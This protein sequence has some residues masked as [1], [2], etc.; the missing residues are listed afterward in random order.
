MT[1][2]RSPIRLKIPAITLALGLFLLYGL[3]K[4][5]GR[6]AVESEAAI[7]GARQS[8]ANGKAFRAHLI[9][10]Q[11]IAQQHAD[12]ARQWQRVASIRGKLI[13]QLDT[14][15]D[16]S[17]TQRESLTVLVQTR[18]TLRAQVTTCCSLARQ[19]ELAFRADSNRAD[20]AERRNGELE[21]HLADVLKV[22]ECHMLGARWLP[23]CP[24]RTASFLLGAGTAG[25]LALLLR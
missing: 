22:A 7:V 3:G 11:Q 13:T 15:L 14:A 23:R 6:G 5:V 9:K 25:S 20:L 21:Q 24:S 2:L 18:D 8:L 12:S 16:R 10:L 4:Y 19:W 1:I 17:T